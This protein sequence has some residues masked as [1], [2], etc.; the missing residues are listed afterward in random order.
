MRKT[1]GR[2]NVRG[3]VAARTGTFGVLVLDLLMTHSILITSLPQEIVDYCV[4][5]ELSAPLYIQCII[6][7]CRIP[8][9][10]EL[11]EEHVNY[12]P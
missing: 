1:T 9:K 12:N 6:L 11:Y 3:G 8:N 10:K 5:F 7:R 4:I 2:N